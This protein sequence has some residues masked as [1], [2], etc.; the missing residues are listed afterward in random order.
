MSNAYQWHFE[1][2]LQ[3][4]LPAKVTTQLI[5]NK[6]NSIRKLTQRAVHGHT[7]K[8]NKQRNY[9]GFGGHS[10]LIVAIINNS[11][12]PSPITS[13][14]FQINSPYLLLRIQRPYKSSF[15]SWISTIGSCFC[16]GSHG[17]IIVQSIFLHVVV[18]LLVM[19]I[20]HFFIVF[21]VVVV[22]WE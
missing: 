5:R 13:F 12:P 22:H 14:C 20:F 8:K 9:L 17:V 19:E 4:P 7:I 16:F 21:F 6:S 1:A 3:T 11:K 15:G 18:W 10:N 2:S